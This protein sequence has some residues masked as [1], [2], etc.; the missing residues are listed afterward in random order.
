MSMSSFLIIYLCCLVTMLLCRCVPLLALKG[1]TL[2]DNLV[3]ALNLIPPAAFAALV[4]ND[5]FSPG[6]FDAGLWQG[7][8]PLAA[9]ALTMI[10]G[11]LR[12]SLVLCIVV[13]VGSYALMMLL[14]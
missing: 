11:Y 12:K 1:R 14:L 2:P 9:A 4:A 8:M 10:V 13:G 7:L 3:R 6:M 5:L